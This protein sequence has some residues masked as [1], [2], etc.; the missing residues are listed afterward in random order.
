MRRNNKKE[1]KIVAKIVKYADMIDR[2][3]YHYA[4]G[5]EY[6]T[7]EL[8]SVAV[9]A[10]WKELYRHGFSRLRTENNEISWVFSIV[11]NAAK[12]YIKRTYDQSELVYIG[13]F[14]SFL[15][16][17]N[18]SSVSDVEKEYIDKEQKEILYRAIENLKPTDRTVA[19]LF[20]D[21]HPYSEIAEQMGIT[22]SDVGTRV[23]RVK[24]KIRKQFMD[25]ER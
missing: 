11:S 13:N 22:E 20:L 19:L 3:C 24:E 7:K 21:G 6:L 5:N 12:N 14:Q 2:I 17:N 15:D 25:Y 23:A 10:L 4:D 8:K 1:E 18:V 9:I 16:R